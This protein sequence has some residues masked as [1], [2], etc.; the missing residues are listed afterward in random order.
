ML[1]LDVDNMLISSPRI[2]IQRQLWQS[3]IENNIIVLLSSVKED[4][5]PSNTFSPYV[6]KCRLLTEDMY[7]SMPRS[8]RQ[9]GNLFTFFN[10]IYSVIPN[11]HT[12][13]AIYFSKNIQPYMA[14]F[15]CVCLLIQPRTPTLYVLFGSTSTMTMTMTKFY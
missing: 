10:N 4:D 12:C 6:F 2:S 11:R 13:M 15:G 9:G 5:K 8:H 3:S 14:L 1:D 7:T